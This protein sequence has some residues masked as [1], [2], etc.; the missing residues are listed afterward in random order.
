MAV[1]QQDLPLP[2]ATPTPAAATAPD[3]SLANT[4][5]PTANQPNPTPPA[6][7]SPEHQSLFNGWLDY[8]QRPEVSTALL[9]FGA[10]M[11]QPAGWGQTSLGQLGQAVGEAGQAVGRYRKGESE[12]AQ[13]AADLEAKKA[14]TENEAKRTAISQQEA[15]QQG[16]YQQGQLGLTKQ[17][18]DEQTR[19][20]I[21]AEKL[22]RLQIGTSAGSSA[23]S[24]AAEYARLGELKRQF[25]LEQAAKKAE[26]E[27]RKPGDAA[28][29]AEKQAHAELLR[30]QADA[31]KAG[32]GKISTSQKLAL[33]AFKDHMNNW[34][35][36]H[37]FA[38]PEEHDAA[39]QEERTKY[40]NWAASLSGGELDPNAGAPTVA[41]AA[42]GTTTTAPATTQPAP[43][44]AS[45]APQPKKANTITTP[46]GK[47][48]TPI[49]QLDPAAYAK[50]KA[51]GTISDADEAAFYTMYQQAGTPQ[52][53]IDTFRMKVNAELEKLPKKKK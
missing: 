52:I 22:Q 38:T 18:Q 46:D 50:H 53:D 35:L 43:T 36:A 21:E 2:G 19:H 9:Q 40:I 17:Q 27:A 4:M 47:Q 20:D 29:L 5:V 12:A 6:P 51:D 16:A 34:E 13:A 37:S 24:T 44:P 41:P 11:L 48:R 30:A 45:G 7:G 10:S 25:D 42:E 26:D 39:E 33:A 32:G 1:A 23:A 28:D 14:Q 3:P 49:N 31:A 15:T 8:L